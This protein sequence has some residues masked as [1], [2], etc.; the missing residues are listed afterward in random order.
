MKREI[1]STAKFFEQFL[2]K[3]KN[4]EGAKVKKFLYTLVVSLE[5]KFRNHWYPAQPAIGN[6]YRC[7]QSIG[8]KIDPILAASMKA[9]NAEFSRLF[10]ANLTVWIDPGEVSYKIGEFGSICELELLENI[11]VFEDVELPEEARA[12][13]ILASQTPAPMSPRLSLIRSMLALPP[14]TIPLSDEVEDGTSTSATDVAPATMG[15]EEEN[16]QCGGGDDDE[17][18][19]KKGLM[20]L[21]STEGS[22]SSLLSSPLRERNIPSPNPFRV[23]SAPRSRRARSAINIIPDPPQFYS[24]PAKTRRA[25]EMVPSSPTSKLAL[26]PSS[27]RRFTPSFIQL[28]DLPENIASLRR[29]ST[30]CMVSG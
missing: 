4:V 2:E 15:A 8:S 12:Q 26:S 10:P 19:R 24:P 5:A 17:F 30:D 22:S 21:K 1:Q 18:A 14:R 13:D 23:W 20:D 25:S 3:R 9:A 6:A 7:L 28:S 11:V 27:A 16:F 29:P